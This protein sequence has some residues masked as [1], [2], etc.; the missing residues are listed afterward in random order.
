V[1]TLRQTVEERTVVSADPAIFLRSRVKDEGAVS[2]FWSPGL[3]R[4][5]QRAGALEH[6]AGLS[7]LARTWRPHFEANPGWNPGVEL[8]GLILTSEALTLRDKRQFEKFWA[9][10]GKLKSE[11]L[12]RKVRPA[13]DRI[14]PR[15]AGESAWRDLLIMVTKDIRKLFR[16]RLSLVVH[17]EAAPFVPLVLDAIQAYLMATLALDQLREERIRF[18]V[19]RFRQFQSVAGFIEGPPDFADRHTEYAAPRRR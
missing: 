10:T 12:A 17:P 4:A 5:A 7:Q 15:G 16:K 14:E 8:K 2:E 11:E 13:L 1:S 3:F 9:L 19:R 6:L 18:M